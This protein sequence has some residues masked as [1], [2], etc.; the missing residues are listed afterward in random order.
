M[1]LVEAGT[2]GAPGELLFVIGIRLARRIPIQVIIIARPNVPTCPG[3]QKTTLHGDLWPPS[4]N[5]LLARL[6]MYSDRK[7]KHQALLD[8]GPPWCT[9]T[10]FVLWVFG[11]VYKSSYSLWNLPSGNPFSNWTLRGPRK[12][13]GAHESTRKHP[14][15]TQMHQETPKKHPGKPSWTQRDTQA[16]PR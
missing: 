12:T 15:D 1:C 6:K 2:S 14:E 11:L 9:D 16:T 4:S 3:D 10:R 5:P 8:L 7:C 13:P